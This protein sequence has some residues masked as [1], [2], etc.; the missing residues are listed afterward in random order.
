MI[1]AETGNCLQL[2]EGSDTDCAAGEW[3]GVNVIAGKCKDRGTMQIARSPSPMSLQDFIGM[4]INPHSGSSRCLDTC[5]ETSES[6]AKCNTVGGRLT[7]NYLRAGLV[8]RNVFGQSCGAYAAGHNQAWN[9][10][11]HSYSSDLKLIPCDD[12]LV[13]HWTMRTSRMMLV[14]GDLEPRPL[15]VSNDGISLKLS[16]CNNRTVTVQWNMQQLKK[17][18]PSPSPSEDSAESEKD[19]QLPPTFMSN[20]LGPESRA[21]GMLPLNGQGNSNITLLLRNPVLVV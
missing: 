1:N 8:G 19:S 12:P 17:P 16:D 11:P 7:T 20:G 9:W 6:G 18:K 13:G 5:L 3:G 15:C 14:G 21:Q 4:V 2:C 10:V